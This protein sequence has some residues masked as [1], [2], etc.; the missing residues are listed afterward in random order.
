MRLHS[1]IGLIALATSVSVALAQSND[2]RPP[3]T[4]LPNVGVVC[5]PDVTGIPPTVG[6]LNAP[7]LSDRLEASKGVICPPAGVDPEIGLL[8]PAGGELKIIPPPGSPGG[9]PDVVP[10]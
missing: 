5:P 2:Q 8:P 4:P 7:T 3:L 1:G 10:K 6:G 9:N